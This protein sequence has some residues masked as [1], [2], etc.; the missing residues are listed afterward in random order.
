MWL[1]MYQSLIDPA[2]VIYQMMDGLRSHQ[3][4]DATFTSLCKYLVEP[5]M[6]K[7]IAC[8]YKPIS[9][10]NKEWYNNL[11]IEITPTEIHKNNYQIT[12]QQSRWSIW[13]ILWYNQKN[14]LSRTPQ[15][16]KTLIQSNI[17][18]QTNSSPMEKTK[19]LPNQQKT[20]V[21]IQYSRNQTHFTYRLFP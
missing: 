10:I 2:T 1:R 11:L 17:I 15:L 21:E 8:I 4:K 14:N 13:N 19:Y 9:S 18:I 7:Q 3:S 5:I 6:A 20:W 12:Q 16:S